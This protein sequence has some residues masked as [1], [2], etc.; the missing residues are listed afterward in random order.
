[1]PFNLLLLPLLGG[2]IFISHWNHTRFDARRYSG[3]RLVFHSALAGVVFLVL[4]LGLG[5]A[6][7][8]WMPGLAEWWLRFVPF[9]YSGTSLLA[10]LLGVVGWMPLNGLVNKAEVEAQKAVE[11]WGDFLELL[12][13]RS[14]RETKQVSLTL[15]SGKV[16]IGFVMSGIDPAFD[17]R[18]LK[19]LPMLSGYRDERTRDM[20]ITRDYARVYARLIDEDSAYLLSIADEFQLVIPTTE[21]VSANLFD[22]DIYR[23]FADGDGASAKGAFTVAEQG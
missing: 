10:F 16:Y 19:L 4:G 3:E 8:A 9:E 18:Y 11:Q 12:I 22:P 7:A 14:I 1:M 23:L 13:N 21:I 15:R 17:R 6:L 2:Y 5:L 20:V